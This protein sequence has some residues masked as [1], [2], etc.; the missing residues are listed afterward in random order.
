MGTPMI[1]MRYVLFFIAALSACLTAQAKRAANLCPEV[2]DD[3]N[4]ITMSLVP[5]MKY[6]VTHFDPSWFDTREAEKAPTLFTLSIIASPPL[7]AEAVGNLRLRVQVLADTSLGRNSAPSSR[8]LALD[9]VTQ[10]L[11]DRY[12]GV[13]LRSNDVFG[14]PYESGLGMPFDE[15][16]LFNYVAE[17]RVVPE[18]NLTFRFAL[19]CEEGA[20]LT[21]AFTELQVNQINPEISKLRNVRTLRALSPGAEINN[22][23]A[24]SIY[25]LTPTF[26]IAS[27][28]FNNQEFNYPPDEDKMEIFVYRVEAGE[29]PKTALDG[30][31]YAKFGVKDENPAIYPASLPLLEPG[32]TYA[33]RARANLRGPTLEYLWSNTLVFK[34][35][36]LLGGGTPEVP[37]AIGDL[38]NFTTQVKY[39]D[40]YTKRVLAALKIILAENYEIFDL[41]RAE[42]IPAKGL[43]RLNGQPVTL[44]ELER[45]AQEF[46]QSRQ[47]LT[48]MRFQ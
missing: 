5:A 10:P 30:L 26:R 43:L 39:G 41:S 28:L 46:H 17:K 1:R 34:V 23:R 11:E 33:W 40:D 38:R 22:N 37:Q 3:P 15:S 27:E 16:E 21:S 14:M 2:T 44:E 42:K 31:E 7:P 6:T 45:L 18:M 4:R 48:R 9:R 25:T 13:P 19:T 29:S 32:R 24:A 20:T 35:D 12:I 47:F 36:A 8:L